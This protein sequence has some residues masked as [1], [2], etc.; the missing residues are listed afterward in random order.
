M[1]F[2]AAGFVAVV[3]YMS[4]YLIHC[5][6]ITVSIPIFHVHMFMFMVSTTE[7]YT[8]CILF[9]IAYTMYLSSKLRSKMP[10]NLLYAVTAFC[11]V[12]LL[13]LQ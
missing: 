6:R 8:T 11:L 3:F 9:H 5:I 4:S 1:S 10:K 12:C 13:Y 2:N 7:S